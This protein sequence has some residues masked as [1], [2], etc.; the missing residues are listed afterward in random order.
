MAEYRCAHCQKVVQ[1]DSEKRWIKSLCMERG[2]KTRLMRVE[3][4]PV[5]L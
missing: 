5:R 3:W 4:P 1:R 2:M